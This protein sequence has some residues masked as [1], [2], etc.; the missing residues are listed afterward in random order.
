MVYREIRT[1]KQG[2]LESPVGMNQP[3]KRVDIVKLKMVKESSLLYKER[4]VKSPEDASLLFKQF[5]DGADR[6]YFI[7]LCLDIKNQPTAINV[8]HIGS[9]NSSIVH[10]R[11]VLKPAIISNAASIIVF[12]IGKLYMGRN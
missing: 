5:L 10:P 6:E 2:V 8:C 4:R 11:E 7:V 1:G 3:A 12:H 9:L